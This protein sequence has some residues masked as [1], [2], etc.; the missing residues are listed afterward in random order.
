MSKNYGDWLACQHIITTMARLF[1]LR[2]PVLRQGDSDVFRANK[3]IQDK[4]QSAENGMSF[5]RAA[6]PDWIILLAPFGRAVKHSPAV[7]RLL[8]RTCH[9][10]RGAPCGQVL[11]DSLNQSISPCR[12]TR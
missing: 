3:M 5:S 8:A 2:S 4:A 7:L 9:S 6:T 12:S 10:Q 11:H 1:G